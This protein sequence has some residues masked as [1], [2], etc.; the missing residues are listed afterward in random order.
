LEQ[1]EANAAKLARMMQKL[2]GG[3]KPVKLEIRA[4]ATA[5]L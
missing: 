4:T 5:A 2:I 3:N 1:F